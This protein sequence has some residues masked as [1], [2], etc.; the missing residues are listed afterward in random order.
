VGTG[1]PASWGDWE[2]RAINWETLTA[3]ALLESGADIVV[4][5][6]PESIIRVKSAIEE[7]AAEPDFV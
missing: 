4:L 1:V 7:L 5:R 6:H 3:I 2:A